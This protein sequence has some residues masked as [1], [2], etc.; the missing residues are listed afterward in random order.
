[1]TPE[2]AVV[3]ALAVLAALLLVVLLSQ[4][5][6]A[7]RLEAI[8][9]ARAG[10]R[11]AA[12]L[13]Q[14]I[15]ALREQFTRSLEANTQQ[16]N[17]QLSQ[18]ATSVGQRLHESLALTQQTHKVLGE[19]LDN[20]SQVVGAVQRSL[21]TLEESNR[22]IYEIG[23]DISSLQ[24][25]LRAPK[26]R[27]GLGELL[28][29]DL[30]GQILPANHVESQYTFRA[31]H[32]VD[33]VIRLGAGMVPVDAKFPLE[34]FRKLLD[35]PNDEERSRMRKLFVVDV[36]RHIDAVA[37]KYILPD[38]GTFDF[39]LMYIPAENVYYEI[40][41][42]DDATEDAHIADYA[43]ARRVIPVSPG[44]FYAYLQAIVMGLRGL[45]IEERSQEIL[46][47]L[48]RLRGEFDRFRDDFR[49][50]GKH[51]NNASSSFAGADRRLERLETR[52]AGVVGDEDAKEVDNGAA[53]P[54]FP[55][56][57]DKRRSS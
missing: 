55:P 49:L 50:V 28:L 57:A 16:V 31:G 56:T 4:R 19:R 18:M 51:L 26:M 38:E 36:K 15:E 25:I 40:V 39:A 2:L 37:T 6:A 52:F 34:N 44:S 1:V 21:G 12:L 47:Q 35:A 42:K 22:K 17:Q 23:K 7:H 53:I 46:Q 11:S 3:A 54:L 43:L 48:S 41:V 24:E 5:R 33:A 30:L 8:E 9:S 14:Q 45:R 10:D 20:T 32:K 13:Q 27:G 29:E